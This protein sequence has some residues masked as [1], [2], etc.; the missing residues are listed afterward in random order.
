VNASEAAGHAAVLEA[1]VAGAVVGKFPGEGAGVK[2]LRSF[3]IGG[4][5]FDV[6]DLHAP[7]QMMRAPPHR[8]DNGITVHIISVYGRY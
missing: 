2:T 6:V 1:G 3:D 7:G 4:R 5:E 8:L